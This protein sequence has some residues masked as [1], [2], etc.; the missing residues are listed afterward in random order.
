M[1]HFAEIG[2]NNKVLRVVVVHNNELLDRD[3][4]EREE[5]GIAFCH[6]VFGPNSRWV[7]TSY[8]GSIRRRFA[9]IDY[10]YDEARDAFIPPKPFPSWQ[11]DEASLD[12]VAPSPKLDTDCYWDEQSLSWVAIDE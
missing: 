11:L 10:D 1:A 2:N 9:S 6:K 3:G 5:R 8:S 4:V 12:W 7:Q